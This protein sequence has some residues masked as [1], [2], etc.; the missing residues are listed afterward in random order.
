MSACPVLSY[1]NV[2]AVAWAAIKAEV[3]GDYHVV[4]ATD[5]GTASGDGFTLGW[6]YS[7]EVG[8]N[9]GSLSIQCDA[10]P[11]WASCSLING[12]IDTLV[13]KCLATS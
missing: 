6:T 11:F 3:L 2:S 10:S 7:P 13:K 5:V 1:T 9:P 12:T 8:R 4:I